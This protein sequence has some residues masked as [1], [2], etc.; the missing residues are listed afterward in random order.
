MEH[1]R[2][3]AVTDCLIES[4]DTDDDIVNVIKLQKMLFLCQGWHLALKGEPLFEESFEAWVHGPA[5]PCIRD[6][7]SYVIS[8]VFSPLGINDLHFPSRTGF[9]AYLS[10]DDIDF[11]HAMLR[12]YGA[13][14]GFQ[15][16]LMVKQVG[17]WRSARQLLPIEKKGAT[18]IT[19]VAIRNCFR[20]IAHL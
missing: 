15:L 20:K 18:I 19:Q 9:N 2:L 4:F 16:E 11:I 5:L 17:A 7:F 6:R 13:Y 10:R 3:N 12:S 8:P 1:T 14:S